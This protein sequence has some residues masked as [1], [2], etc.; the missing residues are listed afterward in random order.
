MLVLTP[1]VSWYFMLQSNLVLADCE[2]VGARSLLVS[3]KAGHLASHSSVAKHAPSNIE[4]EKSFYNSSSGDSPVGFLVLIRGDSLCR[5][6]TVLLCVPG[7]WQLHP[8]HCLYLQVPNNCKQS[9]IPQSWSSQFAN[10]NWCVKDGGAS[11]GRGMKGGHDNPSKISH[12]FGR[13]P[14][15]RVATCYCQVYVE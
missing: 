10:S 12:G 11:R 4:A 8:H 13:C 6:S 1:G 15:C 3:K 2:S 5:T 14:A 9:G 7:P